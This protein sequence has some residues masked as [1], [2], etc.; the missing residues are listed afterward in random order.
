MSV[1]R[2]SIEPAYTGPASAS[3]SVSAALPGPARR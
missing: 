1:P 2:N 3:G